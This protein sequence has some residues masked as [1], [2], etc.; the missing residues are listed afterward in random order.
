MKTELLA[1]NSSIIIEHL[2]ARKIVTLQGEKILT[3]VTRGDGKVGSTHPCSP[4]FNHDYNDLYGLNQQGEMRK[5]EVEVS[6]VDEHTIVINHLINEAR[7]PKG[8]S[9]Q[10]IVTLEDD[11]FSL[12]TTHTNNGKEK[13]AVLTGEHCY[14]DAPQSY[15][16][17]QVNGQ[18]LTEIIEQNKDGV[19]IKLE[20]ENRIEIKGKPIIAL[21]QTG[22]D[23]AMIWVGSSPDLKTKD[24]NYICIEPVE[25]DPTTKWFGTEKSFIEP[26]DQRTSS[27]SL[28]L[29]Q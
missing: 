19:A 11:I 1:N 4:I 13:A 3:K 26:G 18:D 5:T 29:D 28:Q 17:A 14:F 9:V 12:T 24:Q 16:G 7:Y 8:M 15:K 10:Q 22:F 25:A 2:G 23:Y 21:T 6:K 27:F 20:K